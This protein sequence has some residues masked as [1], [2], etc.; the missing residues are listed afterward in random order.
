MFL[1]GV[2]CSIVVL[3]SV[4]IPTNIEEL[5]KGADHILVGHVVGVDMVDK[6]GRQIED[7]NA[8][9]GPGLENTIRLHIVVDEVL[10]TS[11][12]KPVPKLLKV[13]LD[14]FMHYSLGQI[15]SA[16]SKPSKPFLVLLKGSSFVPVV[17]GAVLRSLAEKETALRVHAEAHRAPKPANQP[18]AKRKPAEE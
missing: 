13:P 7:E 8:R 14:P 9:T 11:S 3:A 12:R 18:S 4:P 6:R 5:A 15:K 10:V 2:L 16:H 17:P 1:A